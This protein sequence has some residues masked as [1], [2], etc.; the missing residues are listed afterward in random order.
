MLRREF[1]ASSLSV[2]LALPSALVWTKGHKAEVQVIAQGGPLVPPAGGPIRVAIPI[3]AWNTWI[4]F[5]GPVAAFETFRYD[6]IE[7]QHKALFKPMFV[8]EKLE[9]TGRIVPEYTFGNCPRPEIILVGAQQGSNAL[10]EWLKTASAGAEIT[11]SV[12]TG[13][14]HLAAAGLLDGL[15]ATSHHSSIDDLAKKYPNV[16]WV[17]GMRFVESKRIS[18]GGGLTAGIDLGLRVVERYFGRDWAIEV[19]SHLE[20][21]S[22]SWIV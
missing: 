13:A 11:M 18:T 2:G 12:C 14:Y 3:T 7:K 20:Y 4:D 21:Q 6:P 1:I 5:D 17:R 19:A 16:H 15:Q 9:P 10:T 8:G 22:K